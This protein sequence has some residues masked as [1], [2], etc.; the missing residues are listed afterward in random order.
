ML[1]TLSRRHSLL[2]LF[3]LI[4]SPMLNSLWKLML[5]TM[6]LLQFFSLLMK[7]MKFIWSSFTSTLLL[8]WI[9]TTTHI[10][11]NYLLFLK[12][13]KFGDT[14]WKVWPIPSTL[15][16]IIK[17]LS[18]FLLLRCW[19][20]DKHNGLS[21]SLLRMKEVDLIFSYFLIFFSHFYF[22]F[23]LFPFILFLELG[24]G[25]EWQDHTITQQVTSDDMVT[26]HMTHKRM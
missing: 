23:D 6:L 8:W 4:G 22:I 2:L 25:L 20:R 15:L 24:L 12:L 1:S 16:W 18:I 17:T 10:T 9:W 11:R 21:T 19:P 26:S 3:S 14:I 7:K 13:S 5:Q